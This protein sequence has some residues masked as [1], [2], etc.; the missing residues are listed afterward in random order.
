[1]IIVNVNYYLVY[2]LA[3]ISITK[4]QKHSGTLCA[5]PIF[6]IKQIVVRRPQRVLSLLF[7]FT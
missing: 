4:T 2:D 1:M 6:R 3:D 7:M 5:E